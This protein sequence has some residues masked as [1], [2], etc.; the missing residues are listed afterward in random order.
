MTRFKSATIGL[1]LALL[2]AFGMTGCADFL[3]VNEDPNNP[4][5]VRMSL[6]LPG[7]LIKFGFDLLGPEDMR[8]GNMTGATGWGT[9]WMQH[10]SD[11]RDRHTYAQFQW[12]DVA[13]QDSNE[14]WDDI[15]ADVGQEAV[16][17]M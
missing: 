4:E 15:Y 6:M 12:Y 3:E 10:W 5:T 8:Y 17:I 2:L 16:K 7:M 13:N 14:L 11:N 1:G 9:E